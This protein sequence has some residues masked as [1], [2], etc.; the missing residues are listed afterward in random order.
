M[1]KTTELLRAGHYSEALHEVRASSREWSTQP[2]VR[3]TLLAELLQR[4]GETAEAQRLAE[5]TLRVKNLPP[6]LQARCH[7]VVATILRERGETSDAIDG[8]Q[9]AIAIARGAK[10][11]EQVC[12][13]GLRLVLALA[14]GPGLDSATAY[15]PTLRR[16]VSRLGDPIVS[17][18]L[19]LF[20]AQIET[21]RGL[22]DTAREHVRIGRSLLSLQPNSWLRGTAAIDGFVLSFLRSDLAEARTEALAALNEAQLHGHAGIKRAALANLG[23]LELAQGRW[24][25]AELFLKKALTDPTSKG[26]S[27]VGIVDGLAQIALCRNQLGLA[28]HCRIAAGA[29]VPTH[30]GA[31]GL[32]VSGVPSHAAAC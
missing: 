30:P 8:F 28:E 17:S 11:T 25:T 7:T 9:K 12:S 21:K 32:R 20:V 5:R 19:H 10:D 6:V 18:A 1:D 13:A 16:D 3:D 29:G 23:H 4:T 14:E 26:E 15:I 27:R 31:V 22:L 24:R 2:A